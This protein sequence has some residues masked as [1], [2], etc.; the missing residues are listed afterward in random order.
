MEPPQLMQL[1]NSLSPYYL[2]RPAVIRAINMGG[3]FKGLSVYFIGSYVEKEEITFS[4]VSWV[5]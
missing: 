3:N 1:N 5:V 2:D 4:E